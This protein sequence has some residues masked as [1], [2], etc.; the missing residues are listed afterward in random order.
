MGRV[1]FANGRLPAP[2]R[3]H[4]TGH[5]DSFGAVS[6][7]ADQCDRHRTGMLAMILSSPAPQFGQCCM[8]MS[9]TRLSSRAQLMGPGRTWASSASR[10]AATAASAGCCPSAGPCGTVSPQLRVGRKHAMKPDEVRP[11]LAR[12]AWVSCRRAVGA[13]P[14]RHSQSLI[15]HEIVARYCR[16]ARK[17]FA[18]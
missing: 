4:P 10:L 17:A 3:T 8:S 2:S 11:A 1:V 6:F 5:Q 16:D 18:H 9:N 14:R 7:S 12:R 13:G 15:D